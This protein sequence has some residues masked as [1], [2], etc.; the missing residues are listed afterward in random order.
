VRS[1]GASSAPGPVAIIA[2]SATAREQKNR[3]D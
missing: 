1:G 2:P 3:P